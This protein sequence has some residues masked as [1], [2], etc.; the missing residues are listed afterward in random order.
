[1][2]FDEP[3]PKSSRLP[4]SQHN[5]NNAT[6]PAMGQQ[7]SGQTLHHSENDLGITGSSQKLS[8]S[9]ESTENNIEKPEARIL[10][11]LRERQKSLPKRKEGP[12]QLLEL[13]LDIL[14]DILKEVNQRLP[15]L[16]NYIDR[17]SG[18]PYQ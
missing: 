14:K 10:K 8:P 7:Q 13:P 18:H 11:Y 9:C 1:M 5:D 17:T 15:A 16:S 2:D 4:P 6:H 3:S 12:L